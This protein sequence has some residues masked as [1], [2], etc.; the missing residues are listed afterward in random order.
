MLFGSA[1]K[2]YTGFS[3][4]RFMSDMRIAH[5]YGLVDKVPCYSLLS[6]FM[7]REEVKPILENLITNRRTRSK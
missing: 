4:R 2:I 6:N 7:N 3:L 5:D 1:M